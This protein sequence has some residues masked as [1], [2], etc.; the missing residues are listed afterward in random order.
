MKT[1][2]LSLLLSTTSFALE[3]PPLTRPVEDLAKVVAE[4]DKSSIESAIRDLNKKGIVQISVLVINSLE[5]ENLEEYSMKVAEKWKLGTKEKDNGVLLLVAL[6]DRK[7]RFEVGSGIEGDLTDLEASRIIRDMGPYFRK[8]EFGAGILM[9]VKKV[10][11]TMEY[12]TPANKALRAEEDRIRAERRAKEAEES[13]KARAIFMEQAGNVASGVA[14]LVGLC[15]F[16][17]CLRPSKVKEY[18]E[19]LDKKEALGAKLQED[20][21]KARKEANN[22]PVD[23]EKLNYLK[24]KTRVEDLRQEVQ[25]KKSEIASMKRYLGES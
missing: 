16:G 13:A 3:V 17:M 18:K 2:L 19:I 7:M 5:G 23:K 22:T 12:N 14:V 8:K 21:S 15:L 6:N 4:S 1:I 24:E 25:N 11:Q 9:A 10:D 20:I